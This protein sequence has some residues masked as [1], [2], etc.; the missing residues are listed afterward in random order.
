MGNA[1]FSIISDMG[2]LQKWKMGEMYEG[3]EGDVR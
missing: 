2:F 1:S 3:E